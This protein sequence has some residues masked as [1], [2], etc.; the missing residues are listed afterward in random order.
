VVEGWNYIALPSEP[1]IRVADGQFYVAILETTN[2][3]QIGLDTSS[4]QYSYKKIT[5][6]WEPVTTGE[7]M[8]RAIVDYS[9]SN[10][11]DVLPVCTLDANNYPNPFNPETTISYSVPAAGHASL[12]VYNLKGQLVRELVNETR[13]A[14]RHTVVWNG[15]DANGNAVSSGIYFYSLTSG[16]KTVTRKMLL[17]K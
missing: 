10:D 12:K 8:L 6:N 7:I 9:V 4:N 5:A 16:G 14:G 2:A 13:E 15:K 1:P 3:S 11:D 17:A